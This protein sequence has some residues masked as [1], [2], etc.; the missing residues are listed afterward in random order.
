MAT[1]DEINQKGKVA[2]SEV[3][4]PEGEKEYK[5]EFTKYDRDTGDLLPGKAVE[6]IRELDLINQRAMLVEQRDED[7]ARYN[8]EIAE[9]DAKLTAITAVKT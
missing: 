1:F 6:N 2:V 5:F 4:T 3:I 8:T 9:I 7:V